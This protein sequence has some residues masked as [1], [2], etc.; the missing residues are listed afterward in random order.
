MK[1]SIGWKIVA[2]LL[3]VSLWTSTVSAAGRD[4]FPS[5]VSV[6]DGEG[7]T[8]PTGLPDSSE[9]VPAVAGM[10]V[11][12]PVHAPAEIPVGGSSDDQSGEAPFD[13]GEWFDDSMPDYFRPAE[14]ED[15]DGW[16]DSF[17]HNLRQLLLKGT[18]NARRTFVHLLHMVDNEPLRQELLAD[19]INWAIRSRHH[20]ALVAMKEELVHVEA[21]F[22]GSLSKWMS[23]ESAEK[24]WTGFAQHLTGEWKAA[25]KVVEE[26]FRG[27][28]SD[29]AQQ[30]LGM[31]TGVAVAGVLRRRRRRRR[32]KARRSQGG[33]AGNQAG[34]GGDS[35][36]SD[37]STAGSD[38]GGKGDEAD[39]EW[40]DNGGGKLPAKP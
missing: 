8:S 27:R 26:D 38:T 10:P 35:G 28:A 14:A 29:G 1:F 7:L 20:R 21:A 18:D 11:E 3:V 22:Y 12:E 37:S 6:P 2:V 36:S 34:G 13:A 19:L 32:R 23:T 17:R 33:K 39:E 24:A 15:L 40:G 30:V 5:E 4:K 31:R 9:G 16:M 25:L